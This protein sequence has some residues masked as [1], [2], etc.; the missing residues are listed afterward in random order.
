MQSWLLAE[1][2]AHHGIAV[3]CYGELL[4]ASMLQTLRELQ[5][6]CLEVRHT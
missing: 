1:I 5:S 2:A 6:N 3:S 4:A